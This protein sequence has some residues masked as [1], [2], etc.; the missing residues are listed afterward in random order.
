LR[1]IRTDEKYFAGFKSCKIAIIMSDAKPEVAP[2]VKEASS[3]AKDSASAPKD[4]ARTPYFYSN[5]IPS[6]PQSQ[7]VK[8]PEGAEGGDGETKRS[9]R[10]GGRKPRG[11]WKSHSGNDNWRGG[12]GR[13]HGQWRDNNGGRGEYRNP[14]RRPHGD[15]HHFQKREQATAEQLQKASLA[16]KDD[17]VVSFDCR[18]RPKTELTDWLRQNK[19]TVVKRSDKV[20]YIAVLSKRCTSLTE[21]K[22][23]LTTEDL[24]VKHSDLIDDWDR[25]T[26]DPSAKITYDTVMHLAKKHGVLGG[27]WLF[28]VE[29]GR[30][31]VDSIWMFLASAMASDEDPM[32]CLAIKI[33]PTNDV[34]DPENTKRG[35]RSHMISIYTE[36]FTDE[37]NVFQVEKRLRAIPIKKDLTYKPDMFT[38]LGIYR[39]NKYHL[40]PVIYHSVWHSMSSTS[41]IDSVFDMGWSYQG[42]SGDLRQRKREDRKARAQEALTDEDLEG[43]VDRVIEQT[44]KGI[45]EVPSEQGPKEEVKVDQEVVEKPEKAKKEPKVAVNEGKEGAS[46]QSEIQIKSE[47]AKDQDQVG[48]DSRDGQE[49]DVKEP[50][51]EGEGPAVAREGTGKGP[52]TQ[53]GDEVRKEAGAPAPDVNQNKGGETDREVEELVADMIKTNIKELAGRVEEAIKAASPELEEKESKTDA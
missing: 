28:S 27:K 17:K 36:D 14:Y 11:G 38:A 19:P 24:E 29:A 44:L 13:Y 53:D 10:G 49:A 35:R 31:D 34:D 5:P 48:A 52:E 12:R 43:L 50:E 15:F 32:P 39:N 9:G 18:L 30:E 45:K 7:E 33:T 16:Q 26:N 46:D 1:R 2:G 3:G 40:K 51:A 8:G 22:F 25:L 20:G 6:E 4:P 42:G 41:V 23:T 47:P 21:S 37:D